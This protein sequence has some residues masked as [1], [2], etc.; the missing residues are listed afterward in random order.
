MIWK[1]HSMVGRHWHRWFAWHPVVVERVTHTDAP[2]AIYGTT[3]TWAWLEHVE[4]ELT[5]PM[6]YRTS[7]YRVPA[8][9][10]TKGAQE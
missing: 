5:Y 8:P 2:Q 4:R 6:G 10:E 7:R 3:K 9:G 1:T